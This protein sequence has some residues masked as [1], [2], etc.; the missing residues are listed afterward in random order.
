MTPVNERG[1]QCPKSSH[2]LLL[3][4]D[5]IALR[6]LNLDGLKFALRSGF[7]NLVL[8]KRVLV[9]LMHER[10]HMTELSGPVRRDGKSPVQLSFGASISVAE[11]QNLFSLGVFEIGHLSHL[12]DEIRPHAA[13]GAGNPPRRNPSIGRHPDR[14][15]GE[16]TVNIDKQGVIIPE[17][18]FDI[19]LVNPLE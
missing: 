4:D 18:P 14:M 8:G 9:P 15:L 12:T 17:D 10:D 11:G 1:E 3:I 5:L 6:F 13:I 2:I 19:S 16:G 7:K